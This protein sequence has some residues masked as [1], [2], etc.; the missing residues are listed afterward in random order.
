MRL[1]CPEIR[2]LFWQLVLVVERSAEAIVRWSWWRRWHQAWARYYQY[3][4]RGRQAAEH[5][6]PERAVM[7]AEAAQP[8]VTEVAWSR[9][10]ALLPAEQRVG[11]P[12][13]YE[14]RL[15]FD[16]ILYVQQSGCG[17][18]NLPSHFPPWQTVYAQLRQWRKTGMWDTIWLGLNKPYFTDELQL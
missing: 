1:S 15:V 10:E 5:Q 12:Y 14:R 8:D 3:R 7:H 4:G 17:W 13:D 18:R 16:A 6:P 11:R 2:R 9:L